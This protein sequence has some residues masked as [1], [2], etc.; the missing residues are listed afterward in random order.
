MNETTTN[1]VETVTASQRRRMF[2]EMV[3]ATREKN[4][5]LWMALDAVIVAALD[6]RDA[7]SDRQVAELAHHFPS[8]E[9]AIL[10]TW[11]HIQRTGLDPCVGCEPAPVA[12]ATS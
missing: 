12:E 7:E 2:A 4:P 6:E 1:A 3:G 10:L 8:L 9:N 5:H 11:A